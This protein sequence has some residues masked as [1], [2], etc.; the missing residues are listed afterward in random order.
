[1]H[2]K[3]LVIGGSNEFIGAPALS[4][5]S[6]L[7]AL[8]SG[9]DIVTVCAPEKAGYVINSFSPDLIVKKFTGKFFS[10]KNLVK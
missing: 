3:V 6:A 7:A 5:L 8:R 9:V 4:A 2:G 1:M 10:S